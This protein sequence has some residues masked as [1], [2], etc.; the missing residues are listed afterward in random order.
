MIVSLA[1]LSDYVRLSVPADTLAERL[2]MAGL[3]HESTRRVGDDT[4][5]ELEVTSNRPDCLGH[6]GIAREA[7]A[8]FSTPLHVPEPVAVAT[9]GPVADS[10]SIAIVDTTICPTT[11][12]G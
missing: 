12:R 2:A 10:I 7:S 8:I 11:R 1:W 3:N 6:V 9:G 5:I 4:A